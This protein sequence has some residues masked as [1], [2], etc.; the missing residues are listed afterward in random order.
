MNEIKPDTA[1]TVQ[2]LTFSLAGEEY[3][4]DILAVREI[5]GWTRVTRIPQAPPHVL[6]VLNL[7]GTVL[8]VIDLRLRFGLEKVAHDANT[9]LIVVAQ[10]PR[11]FGLVVDAVD[12]VIDLAPATIQ[13]LPAMGAIAAARYL[14]GLASH[15]G[16]TLLLLDLT[17]LLQPLPTVDAPDVALAA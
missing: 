10:G 5:R 3:G 11:L 14:S 12:E 17:A 4:I 2:Q 13:P 6:G 7:R 9:A 16:R 1:T 8:P 15:A